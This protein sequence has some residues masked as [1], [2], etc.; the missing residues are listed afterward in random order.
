MT[1]TIQH[2][3]TFEAQ[4]KTLSTGTLHIHVY[5]K[6]SRIKRAS[7]ALLGCW[8]G[9]LLTAPIIILHFISVPGLLL[10]GPYFAYKFYHNHRATEKATGTC[11]VCAQ[12]ITIK[13]ESAQQPP[14]YSYCPECREPLQLIDNQDTLPT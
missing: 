7:L 5:D 2:N 9:A 4:D 14:I 12:V 10:A 1:K 3:I 6:R 8:I 11:P 13:L